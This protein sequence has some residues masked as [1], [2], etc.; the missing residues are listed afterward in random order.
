M[1]A[2]KPCPRSTANL[3]GV[4]FHRFA[5]LGDSFTEGV[6]DPDPRLPHGV[7]G[8]A[9]RVAEVLAGEADDFR[10]ANFAIRGRKLS[11]VMNEQVGP[12]LALNPDLVSVYAGA[13]DVLRPRVD[14]DG[15]IARYDESLGTIAASGAHLVVFTAYDPGHSPI[16][17]ALRGRFAV[18]NELVREVATKYGA[19]VVDFWRLRM[20]RDDRFWADDRIH[21]SSIGHQQMA[22][23]VLNALGIEHEL[24]PLPL[25]E[26]PSRTLLQRGVANVD[27]ATTHVGPWIKRRLTGTSSGDNLAPRRPQLEPVSRH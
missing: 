1:A 14:I 16:F 3:A 7:R 27:W 25:G 13:N 22:I 17:A 19:T 11:G 26:E 5:A 12:A 15:L 24:H 2:S 21:M 23:E 10:Y 18:Y 6:G 20:Y 8:W 4:T 9:D